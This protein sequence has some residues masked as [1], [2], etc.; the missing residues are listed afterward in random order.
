MTG[1]ARPWPAWSEYGAHDGGKNPSDVDFGTAKQA[2]IDMYGEDALWQS[3]L[4]VCRELTSVTGE[5]ASR[6]SDII[7]IFDSTHILEHGFTEEQSR[8]A[9][10]TGAFVCRETI[11]KAEATSLYTELK[12]YLSANDGRIPAWP[13]ES[14]S[15][16]IL[17]DSPVQNKLRAHPNHLK[18]QRM[19]N[20]LWHDSTGETSPEPLVY[21][22]GVRD[23]APGQ[24]FLGLGPHID[25]GSLARW[26][27]PVYR[28]V[29]HEVFSRHPERFDAYDLSL[30]KDAKQDLY[31]AMAHSSVF[32][33]FQGWTALTPTS[34]G[35]GTL[36][37]Y[38]NVSLVIAYVL[39]RPFF[40]PPA[41]SEELL[42][43]EKWKLDTDSDYFPGTFKS[44]SQRL[45]RTSHPHL[46][47]EECMVPMPPIEPGDTVW[48]HTDV[49]L[50]VSRFL[51]VWSFTNR[52]PDVPRSRSCP[53][54]R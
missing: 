25:A 54:W 10:S 32:R 26:A 41:C 33:S 31:K 28:R 48:W 14:P 7:P 46:R 5:I 45:S 53:Q 51:S 36:L 1:S 44:E 52:H 49:R 27:D 39:L 15:M 40:S 30:R 22:D 4:R 43:P 23:R 21:L 47:L 18:L 2:V 37:V 12:S 3:W 38:P 17:Y 6:R 34:D 9:K 16:L 11:P 13:K 42:D 20:D 24:E 29:Y 8:I 35:K 50:S 19:L